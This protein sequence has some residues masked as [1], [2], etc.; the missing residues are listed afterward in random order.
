MGLE[1]LSFDNSLL[2]FPTILIELLKI[3]KLLFKKYFFTL[4]QDTIWVKFMKCIVSENNQ[5]LPFL[6]AFKNH[7]D[8]VLRDMI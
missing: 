5:V 3:L 7:L 4:F 6:D 2:Y 8:V 1:I